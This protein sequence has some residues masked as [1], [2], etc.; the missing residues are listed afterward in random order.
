MSSREKGRGRRGGRGRARATEISSPAP[1]GDIIVTIQH[2][3]IESLAPDQ[4]DDI[5]RITNSQYLTSYNWLGRD[6]SRIIVPGEP[7]KWTPL[8]N[9]RKLQQDKGKYYRDRNAAQF[10][11]YPLEPMVQAILADKPEFPVTSVDIIGC[12][13]TMGNLLRFARGDGKPFRILVEVLGKTVFFIRRENS[14]TET[15]PGIRG[16]GHTFPEAYTR[17]G[18][19]VDGSQ[20]HQRVV[21]YEF[22]GMQCLVRYEAD[23]FLPD[24]VP[25]PEEIEEDPVPVPDPKEESINPEEMLPSIEEKITSDV[26]SAS[27]EMASKQLDIAIQGQRIPQCAVFDLKTRSRSKR[28]VKVLEEEFP[29]LWLTQT[30]NFVLGHHTSGQF[31]HIRVQDM[32]NDVKQWE[33]TQQPALGKF[34]SLLQM[35][36]AFARSVDNGKIE[37]ERKEG[38]YCDVYLTHDSMSVR[39]AHNSGRNHLRNVVDYYQQ[40]GQEKAQSVIDSITSSYA[41]E[42]Q[43]APNMMPPG[44]FPPPFGFPGMPGMPPPPFG[45]PPPGAPGAPGMLPRMFH[46]FPTPPPPPKKQRQAY[47]TYAGPNQTNQYPHPTAPGAHGL[48]FPPPFPGA[49]GTPPTGGF[50]PPLPNMPQGANLPIPPPGGFPNFPIPPPGAAGFPPMPGQPGMGPGGPSQIPTGPRGLE[51]YPPPPGGGPPGGMDQRW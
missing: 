47:P 37:I 51:G 42:G 28:T 2:N 8:S 11:T 44:A 25:D 10:P 23:G 49:A 5:S 4:E 38:D 40:I 17:W 46:P 13:N 22:A 48:P 41:A 21:E 12:G 20:S 14:P 34:A 32:R 30:P 29:R 9:P 50:P 24:L 16:Y 6:K 33:E 7:P 19:N 31:N 1:L 26:P 39:K 36:V 27:T 45:I 3:E 15:I 43:Q 35:I 18:P